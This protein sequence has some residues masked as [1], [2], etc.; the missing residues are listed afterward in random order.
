MKTIAKQ[1]ENKAKWEKAYSYAKSKYGAGQHILDV[2]AKKG[3]MSFS[4]SNDANQYITVY[5]G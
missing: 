4:Y 1:K 3:K 2:P 5:Y